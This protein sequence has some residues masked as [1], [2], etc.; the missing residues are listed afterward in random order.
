MLIVIT[1]AN[2]G[3]GLELTRQLSAR[4]DRVIAACRR[5]SPELERLKNVEIVA[6]VDVTSDVGTSRLSDAIG[7]RL[8]DVLIQN[9]GILEPQSGNPALGFDFD[10]IR[11]QIEVNALGPMRVTAALLRNMPSGSKLAIISSRA[12]SIGDNIS[13]GLYGYRMSKAALNMAAMS[14][15]RDLADRGVLVAVLHP[16]FVKTDMTAGNGNIEPPEAA[17][18]LIA[19][20]DGLSKDNT[21]T[22]WHASGEVLP[23]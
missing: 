6:D 4:G 2:R 3:I 23:W 13:G 15:A 14:L 8:I 19:R 9:A 22:F 12:G 5:P 7:T 21:G 1:G 18:G 20:I 10:S 17:R 11:R 16:G